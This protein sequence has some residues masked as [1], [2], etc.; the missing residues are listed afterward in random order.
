M[1]PVPVSQ[2][3]KRIE[4]TRIQF[5]DGKDF[6]CWQALVQNVLQRQRKVL[7]NVW[8]AGDSPREGGRGLWQDGA[9]AR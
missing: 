9:P 2:C 1:M 4:G 8:V 5:R 6:V 3:A 7:L